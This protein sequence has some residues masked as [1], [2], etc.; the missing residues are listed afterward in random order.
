M[1]AAVRVPTSAADIKLRAQ[2]LLRRGRV[3]D[4]AD[5]VDGFLARTD[6]GWHLWRLCGELS[7]RLGRLGAAVAAFRACA[8]QLEA[9]GHLDSAASVLRHALRLAPLDDQLRSEVRRLGPAR[10]AAVLPLQTP[11]LPPRAPGRPRLE[12]VTDPH[13]AIFDI[14]DAEAAQLAATPALPGRPRRHR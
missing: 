12:S 10:R 6:A 1:T 13:L 7:Q 11:R 14:L 5:L 4:A 8:R 3:E 2:A 9:A